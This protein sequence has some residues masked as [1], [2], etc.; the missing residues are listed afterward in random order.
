MLSYFC[1]APKLTKHLSRRTALRGLLGSPAAYLSAQ[2][3]SQS[4]A[5]VARDHFWI[6][7]VNAGTNDDRLAEGGIRGGSRMTPA[8]GAF[9][10]DVPNLILV[11]ENNLPAK[12]DNQKWRTKTTYEQFAISFLPLKRVVWSVVGSAGAISGDEVADVVDL[13]RK[14]P[15]ISGVYSDDFFLSNGKAAKSIEQLKKDRTRLMVGGRRLESWLTL[16]THQLDP[17][18]KD[19]RKLDLPLQDYLE[20][21]D[22]I[23]MWTWNSDELKDL[24]TNLARL[25]KSAPHSR[26]AL[27]CYL[28]DFYNRKPV[29]MELMQK[30]C[31][32][33]LAWMKEGRIQEMVFLANSVLDIGLEVA[34]WTRAWIAKNGQVRV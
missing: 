27:G 5:G 8:E 25:E 15:N 20:Q 29:P 21:F 26:R 2:S 10:L 33:G 6:F 11:R 18:H 34:D 30:Q 13:A 12:P 3:G 31:N 14:Y 19:K 4:A 16:Y 24:E 7:G 32:T 1:A 9:F 17:E 22:V 23:T 28:W